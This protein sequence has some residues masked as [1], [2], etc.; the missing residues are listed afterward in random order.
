M[1]PST[2]TSVSNR[3]GEQAELSSLV[4]VVLV[5]MLALALLSFALPSIALDTA[6]ADAVVRITDTAA[7]Q[8]MPLLCAAV[9]IMLAS[10]KGLSA[11]QRAIE[12]AIVTA[13]M[14]LFLVGTSLIN[15]NV[16]KPLF[17][18]PRPNI[19]TLTASGGLGPEYPDAD[20]FYAAGD[21]ATRR[22]LLGE[23]LPS[24]Q[25]PALSDRVR[26]HWIHEAGYAFPS[27]H[28]TAAMT[29]AGMMTAF[30]MFW[31]SGWRLGV[32]TVLLPIWALCVVYSR[33]LLEVHTAADVIA[34]TVIGLVLGLIAFAS[35]RWA[36]GRFAG[37][38]AG[39]R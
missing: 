39:T 38:P 5:S 19:V 15:E 1:S 28:S 21:K 11:R 9:L 36:S 29:L 32:T 16:T 22:E 3:R 10:R 26:A 25:T 35:I 8:R 14:L 23:H 6:F 4:A 20:A 7:W 17:G 2:E 31:L 34:G 27:G 37:V 24:L 33:P 13:A 12:A 18:I 30:G